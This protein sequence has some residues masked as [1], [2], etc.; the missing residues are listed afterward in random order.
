MHTTIIVDDIKMV[1][2]DCN[3]P[4]EDNQILLGCF[5]RR[6]NI[7][8]INSNFKD[9]TLIHEFAHA[10]SWNKNIRSEEKAFEGEEDMADN[11][12]EYYK[13]PYK[14]KEKEPNKALFFT[15]YFPK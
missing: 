14:Y 7:I 1:Q 3:I 12:V 10:Y 9:D 13:N 11:Y 5:D 4:H 6:E 8:I 15:N 2:Y